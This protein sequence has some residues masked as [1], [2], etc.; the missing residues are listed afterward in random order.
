[1]ASGY[2]VNGVDFDD[3]FDPDVMGNGPAAPGFRANGQPLRYAHI[4]YGSKGPN[5]GR[6][7]A[8]VDIS[9]L[10]ARK[11]SAVYT[12]PFNGKSFAANSAAPTNATG[13]A[14]ASIT[15]TLQ[16]DGT[17]RIDRSGN[18]GSGQLLLESGVWLPT[19]QSVADYEVMYSTSSPGEASIGNAAPGFSSLTVSRALSATV[20]TPAVRGQYKEAA[21]AFYVDMRRGGAVSRSILNVGVAAAGW[22]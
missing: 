14:T 8:G 3:L 2:R 10:W 12:L 13:T 5:V 21:V 1:M 4:Q 20:T 17:Y 7:Q 15:L 16:S 22:E 19:G 6:R 9:T 11:G 18:F